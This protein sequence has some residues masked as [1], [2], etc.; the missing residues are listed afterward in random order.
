MREGLFVRYYIADQHFFHRRMNTSMDCRGFSSVEEMN[1]FMIKQWNRKVRYGDEVVILGDLSLCKGKETNE[2]LRQ[3]K[4]RKFLVTGNHDK[5]VN[6]KEFD[7]SLLEWIKPYEEMND[8]GRKVVLCHYFIPTYN[9]QY[10]RDKNG[11]PKTWML[12]GH[13]HNTLDMKY[14]DAYMDMVR[15]QNRKVRG[16]IEAEA[17]P[18]QAINCF[19]MYSNYT[20]LTLDEWIAVENLRRK[21][22]PY[23]DLQE[24]R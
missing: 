23:K 6:D 9:G 10:R 21:K 24:I 2:I 12:F 19:C 5:F 13:V 22:F 4:G 11:N 17:V 20:P 15:S 7:S 18:I 1:E 3:L 14:I 8:N 16:L